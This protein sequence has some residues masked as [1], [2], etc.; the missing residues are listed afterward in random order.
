MR[1]GV[2]WALSWTFLTLLSLLPNHFRSPGERLGPREE[3]KPRKIFKVWPKVQLE[4]FLG[5]WGTLSSLT[6]GSH[7]VWGEDASAEAADLQG[8]GEGLPAET[9]AVL[10]SRE[11]CHLLVPRVPSLLS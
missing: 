6:T 8:A 9:E 11:H 7:P 3:R 2:N 5:F 4:T 1:G 10:V